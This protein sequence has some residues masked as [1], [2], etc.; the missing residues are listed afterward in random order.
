MNRSRN[1]RRFA[2]VLNAMWFLGFCPIAALAAPDDVEEEFQPVTNGDAVVLGGMVENQFDQMVFQNGNATQARERLEARLNLQIRQIDKTCSLTAAQKEKL[3][4]A[5]LGDTIR[6]FNEVEALRKK[7]DAGK[8]D[9]N[10]LDNIWNE[11]NPL[12]QK[13]ALG[14]YGP[15]SFYHK[16]LN[17]T[18]SPEQLSKHQ[19]LTDER[20]RSRYRAGIE[21]SLVSLGSIAA[22]TA[23]QHRAIAKLLYDL[24]PPPDAPAGYQCYQIFKR[25]SE[26][27]ADKL[28]PLVNDRQWELM[29]KFFRQ[30]GQV[31][32]PQVE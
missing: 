28:K 6:Y 2:I 26:L 9:A 32:I 11:I 10:V 30:Y 18:L 4:L 17:K 27:P 21:T 24:P 23:E 14:I 25:M 5:A 1:H 19:L 3:A 15:K 12:Q 13:L 8:N 22:L 20:R 7:F 16:A 31:V 29:Q